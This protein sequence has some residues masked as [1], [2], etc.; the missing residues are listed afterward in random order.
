MIMKNKTS[1]GTFLGAILKNKVVNIGLVFLLLVAIAI[2]VAPNFLTN[3]NLQSVVRDLAF[4]GIIAIGQSCLLL[5]GELDLSVGNIAA[6]CGVV[7]GF[8]M[9]FFK[10]N[11]YLSFV[12]CVLLGAVLGFINGTIITRLNLNAMVVTIGM[13]GVYGGFNLVLTK[14]RAVTNIPDS[15]FFLGKGNLFDVPMPFVFT[16][17]VMVI[18]VFIMKK[19]AFGRYVYAIGNNV[20]AA[21]ILGIKVKRVRTI[22]Y[23]L[24][25]MLSALAG[26]LMVARLGSSQPT[27]GATWPMNS[28][29]ASVIGGVALTGGIGNPAGALIGA[30]II[31]IIQNIIVLL[32]VSS[33]WQTVVSG[34]VVVV[35][36]SIGSISEMI[37]SRKKRRKRA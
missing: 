24:M 19:T 25:G 22:V 12:L 17:A 30:A 11:P 2:A 27:I 6:L 9:V 26:M 28:I 1:A 10:M 18:V 5:L 3:Y 14:G 35:A 20:Q 34:T 37:R 8:L 7:G 4:V 36:I 16:I 21:E 32:G 15:I 31:S 23:M 33:Y 29:A 13:Q